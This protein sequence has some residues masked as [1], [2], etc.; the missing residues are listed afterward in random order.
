[1][2][3]LLKD[4]RYLMASYKDIHDFLEQHAVAERIIADIRPAALDY[5]IRNLADIDD[6]FEKKA[7]ACIETDERICIVFQDGAHMEIEF[8]GEGPLILGFNTADF[9]QYPV[10]DGTCYSLHTLFKHCLGHRIS[11]IEYPTSDHRML[12]PVYRGVNTS[13]DDEGIN[14]ISFIL[15]NHTRLRCAGSQDWFSVGHVVGKNRYSQVFYKNL[16]AELNQETAHSIFGSEYEKKFCDYIF[17]FDKYPFLFYH[18]LQKYIDENKDRLIGKKIEGYYNYMGHFNNMI[19][20]PILLAFDEFCIELHYYIPSNA[21][22]NVIS[23]E[24]FERD[25]AMDFMFDGTEP[26]F[27]FHYIADE[28]FPLKGIAIKD[29]MID[30]FSEEFEIDGPS[31]DTRPEGGDYFSTIRLLMENGQI[32]CFCGEDAINDGYLDTWIETLEG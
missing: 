18:E 17:G 19:D 14:E 23:R 5:I 30:R 28:L 29:I 32:W 31:G 13:E 21:V 2:K 12:F 11:S 7:Y 1:M 10:Y 3:H 9:S 16:F 24:K 20:G 22:I 4:G 26:G 8:S 25:H 15:D 6:V 27:E